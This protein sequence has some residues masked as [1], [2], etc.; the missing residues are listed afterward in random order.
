MFKRESRKKKKKKKKKKKVYRVFCLL[1]RNKSPSPPL[2]WTD[3]GEPSTE[4]WQLSIRKK[5][6]A[7]SETVDIS[8]A[9]R[10]AMEC[11]RCSPNG[12]IPF[13]DDEIAPAYQ[14]NKEHREQ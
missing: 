1:N 10:V 2:C 5:T 6:W 7:F 8:L 4:H 13:S 14:L 11:R 3:P 12:M 9:S